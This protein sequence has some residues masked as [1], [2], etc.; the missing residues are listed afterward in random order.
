LPLA[1]AVDL[2]A[3]DG[4][5]VAAPAETSSQLGRLLTRDGERVVVLEQSL[6]FFIPE[7]VAD[8][9]GGLPVKNYGS[10]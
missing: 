10:R 2:R 5:L 8:P 9:S 4:R 1:G 6:A 7:R 3:E